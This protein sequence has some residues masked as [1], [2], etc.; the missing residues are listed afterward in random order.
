MVKA[1]FPNLK[2]TGFN[3]VL[4][5]PALVQTG[6]V[7]L[8]T[9]SAHNT[10][11]YVNQFKLDVSDIMDEDEWNKPETW[12]KKDEKLNIQDYEL[13]SLT[14]YELACL[15]QLFAKSG[16]RASYEV[17]KRELFSREDSIHANKQSKQK[18]LHRDFKRL[19]KYDDEDY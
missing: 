14:T 16:Q 5:D 10:V 17:V 4:D 6:E 8:V 15:L 13:K 11:P 3:Q 18:A 9:D 7:L 12:Q 1:L 19:K 2:R